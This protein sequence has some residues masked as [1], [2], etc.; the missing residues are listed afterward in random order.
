MSYFALN[1]ECVDHQIAPSETPADSE[2]SCVGDI[3]QIGIRNAPF[4]E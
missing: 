3:R 4:F 2:V 1:C